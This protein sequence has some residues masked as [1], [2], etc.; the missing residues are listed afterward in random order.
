MV[1]GVHTNTCEG[2]WFHAKKHMRRG[3][4]RSRSD[5][6]SLSIALCEFMW[7]KKQQLTR[8]EQSIKQNFGKEIPDLMRRILIDI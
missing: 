5:S 2:M 6:S 3:T 1:T 8:D 7:M 4:G